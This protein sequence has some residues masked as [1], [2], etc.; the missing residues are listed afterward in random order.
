MVCGAV[1]AIIFLMYREHDQPEPPEFSFNGELA[2]GEELE[3]LTR[4]AESFLDS[5]IPQVHHTYG[6]MPHGGEAGLM[7]TLEQDDTPE[8]R[9]S[10][11]ISANAGDLDDSFFVFSVDQ[12]NTIIVNFLHVEQG[13]TGFL[14]VLQR[15]KQEEELDDAERALIDHLESFSLNAEIAPQ[16]G[17]EVVQQFWPSDPSE[18]KTALALFLRQLV[19]AHTRVGLRIHEASPVPDDR[20]IVLK[21]EF[22]GASEDDDIDDLPRLQILVKDPETGLQ[23][24]YTE[25]F[26]G[27]RALYVDE[28]GGL[29]EADAEDDIEEIAD[30]L[31]L[32]E[33]ARADVQRMIQL[34]TDVWLETQGVV[35]G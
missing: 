26:Y 6:Y 31:G 14:G 21:H 2:S 13:Y 18:E 11:T 30:L 15:V 9:F 23:Y 25:D 3:H 34:L 10:A 5:T 1:F 19:L 27:S 35:A 32:Y 28:T 24:C 12:D 8:G 17:E 22:V 29:G 20:V 16:V 7:F 4:L 33:P